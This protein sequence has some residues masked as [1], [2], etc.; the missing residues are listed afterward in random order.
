LAMTATTSG[1]PQ[2]ADAKMTVEVDAS[3]ERN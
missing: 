3:H 2:K 1:L